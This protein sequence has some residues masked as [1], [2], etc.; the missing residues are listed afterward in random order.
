MPGSIIPYDP[1]VSVTSPSQLPNSVVSSVAGRSR[2]AYLRNGQCVYLRARPHKNAVTGNV[3][4]VGIEDAG[5]VLLPAVDGET[6]NVV[7]K[8]G[9]C[10]EELNYVLGGINRRILIP[11]FLEYEFVDATLSD[12]IGWSPYRWYQR[13]TFDS[14]NVMPPARCITPTI[15]NKVVG[16]SVT[17][18]L[19]ASQSVDIQWRWHPIG[20][21]VG[22]PYFGMQ[23]YSGGSGV[24]MTR[25]YATEL[26]NGY[27]S[28]LGG[29]WQPCHL[30]AIVDSPMNFCSMLVDDAFT[31][32]SSQISQWAWGAG[33]APIP[34]PRPVEEINGTYDMRPFFEPFLDLF[35]TAPYAP[36]QAG[37][38][39]IRLKPH[40]GP[41]TVPGDVPED[42]NLIVGLSILNT[43]DSVCDC[44]WSGS[45][46]IIDEQFVS[47][48][49]G[50]YVRI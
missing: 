12:Q 32:Q 34:P 13:F 30:S 19:A 10:V 49:S 47:V 46:Q 22:R 39:K 38:V 3:E 16:G 1:Y 29:S 8:S 17:S 20:T 33:N 5:A 23:V 15:T 44:V 50:A 43:A 25:A 36:G 45:L 11:C 2:F 40:G 48:Q 7:W 42:V 4:L 26:G 14:P 24:V 31:G 37:R 18:F 9:S 21:S 27:S 6:N 35:H 28:D 41:K